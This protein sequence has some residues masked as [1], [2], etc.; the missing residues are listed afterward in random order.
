[1]G[2]DVF[3]VISG[4]LIT[5]IIVREIEADEFSI[6]KF[7]ERRIRRIYPALYVT[8]LFVLIASYFLYSPEN[9]TQASK[10]SMATI[11]FASNILFWTESG[12]F[13]AP[14]TLTPLLHTWSLAVEEQFYIVFPWLV[15]L[16]MHYAK[17]WLQAILG[18]LALLSFFLSVYYI[19]QDTSAAF[20]FTHLRAWELMIGGLLAIHRVPAKTNVNLRQ[21]LSIAGLG[22]ILVSVLT[23]TENTPFP[24][25]SALLPTLGSAFIIY[26]GMDGESLVGKVLSWSPLVF[27]GKISYSLYLWHWPIIIFGRYYMIQSPTNL[28]MFILVA[29]AFIFSS[30]SWLVVEKPFRS[31][32]FLPSPK[33]F[34]FAG[35]VMAIALAVSGL[36]YLKQGIPS[37]FSGEEL[38]T[39]SEASPAWGEQK[40]CIQADL[41][42]F[43][44][45]NRCIL[46]DGSSEPSF[47]VWGDS[48]AQAL[49]PA[50]DSVA[51]N[52]GMTGYLANHPACP[53]LLDVYREGDDTCLDFNNTVLGYIEAHPEWETIIL[54]G[55]WALSA[56]GARYKT[57]EGESATLIDVQSS[58][59][60]GSNALIF[61]N[62]LDRTVRKLLELNRRV[63]IVSTVPEVGYDVPS[64]YFIALRTGQDINKIVAPTVSEYRQ[65]NAVVTDVLNKIQSRYHVQIIDPAQDLCDTNICNVVMDG[66]PL[67]RDAHHISTLGALYISDIF[68][69]LFEK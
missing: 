7:Y 37:R 39:F 58:A 51:K 65:R 16:I 6:I 64:A 67:Y 48:H 13:A 5:T 21:L 33:I 66:Q 45:I 43:K 53:T 24:G 1:V 14:S 20:Y 52:N 60:P 36:F 57:E 3:F 29:A 54:S 9:F 34:V 23:Y 42:A 10:S 38:A 2:V 61:E 32:S 11:G 41:K 31:K 8:L 50:F 56:D 44:E 27:I 68:N 26:S 35:S 4:F 18:A 46:G 19:K 30:F 28:Q 40:K 62:G 63:I 15:L 69:P 12:Y 55:R 47:I 17:K 49:A 22:M 59:P 25:A